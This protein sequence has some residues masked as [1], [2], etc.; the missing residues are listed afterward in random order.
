MI[1]DAQ[2]AVAAQPST[3]ALD[4]PAARQHGES[5]LADVL[6]HNRELAAQPLTGLRATGV[7]AAS[8]K[9]LQS[10]LAL[11][12]FG[13]HRLRAVAILSTGQLHVDDEH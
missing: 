5:P 4:Y 8:P 11:A 1:T 7:A 13:Q 6:G 12:R 10:E 2:A 9:L 3:S